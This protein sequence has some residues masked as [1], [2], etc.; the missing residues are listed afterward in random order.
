[1]HPAPQEMARESQNVYDSYVEA[2][3]LLGVRSEQKSSVGHPEPPS[4]PQTPVS[5]VTP[6]DAAEDFIWVTWSCSINR[7]EKPW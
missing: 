3:R 5:L 6:L 2:G 1:M 4:S 7:I